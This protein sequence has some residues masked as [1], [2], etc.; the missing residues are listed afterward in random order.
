MNFTPTLSDCFYSLVGGSHLYG[1]STPQSDQDIR[2][3]VAVDYSKLITLNRPTFREH[4]YKIAKNPLVGGMDCDKDYCFFELGH[5]LTHCAKG[6]V[7]MVELLFAPTP[8]VDCDIITKLRPYFCNKKFAHAAKGYAIAEYNKVFGEQNVFTNKASEEAFHKLCSVFQINRAERD[9]IINYLQTSREYN[10]TERVS[11]L[12][13]IDTKRRT[14]IEKYGYCGKSAGH[15]V[16]IC[17]QAIEYLNHGTMTFP[18]PNADF[19][20]K[21]RHHALDMAEVR[22]IIEDALRRLQ[23]AT[24]IDIA[25][26]VDF[27]S[28]DSMYRQILDRVKKYE[29]V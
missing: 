26:A 18:R 23:E 10:I 1:Y 9:Y 24:E 17:E 12:A 25:P 29:V 8:I 13:Q 11:S 19:L 7:N 5:F 6:A 15:T 28:L 22:D 16:R 3:I 21:I 14:E 2:G 4:N 27:K 20:L